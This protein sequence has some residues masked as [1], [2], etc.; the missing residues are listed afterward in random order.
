MSEIKTY[1]ARRS[2]IPV[3]VETLS[4]NDLGYPAS[5]TSEDVE[6]EIDI[7][8]V[9]TGSEC[10]FGVDSQHMVVLIHSYSCKCLRSEVDGKDVEAW[11][12]QVENFFIVSD[13][14]LAQAHDDVQHDSLWHLLE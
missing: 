8:L 2:T 13:L 4:T 3:V 6:W 12:S 7:E 9:D 1:A 5:G 10:F 11:V 14:Y